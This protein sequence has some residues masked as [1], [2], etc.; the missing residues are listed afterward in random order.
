MSLVLSQVENDAGVITFNHDSKRNALSRALIDELISTLDE[1]RAA[2]ARSVILRAH[3]GATVW[4]AG[5]DVAE[6]P[7]R[8]AIHLA[9]TTRSG[10]SCVR[11]RQF[12]CRSSQ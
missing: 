5:H 9:T 4:S 1:I 8:A 11:S 7:D 6:L 12:P 10:A 3:P 2:G